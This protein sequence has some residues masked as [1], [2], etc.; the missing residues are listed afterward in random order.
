MRR[1]WILFLRGLFLRCPMCG[2]G[3]LFKRWLTMYDRCPVCGFPYE[4]EEGYFTGAMAINLVISELLVAA[5]IVPVAIM[6][7]MYPTTTPTVLLLIIGAPL[8]VL[9]PF[10]FFRHS[11]GLWMSVD[12]RLKRHDTGCQRR[13]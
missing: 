11:R 4:R 10:L 6:A 12:H 9:L 1:A 5:Y 7:G 3:K 8:P 13:A 2:K